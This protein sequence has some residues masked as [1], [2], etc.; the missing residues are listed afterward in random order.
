VR[1]IDP[2]SLI[3]EQPIQEGEWAVLG[4]NLKDE[5]DRSIVRLQV[6]API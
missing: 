3:L 4:L 5:G 2:Q 6:V 1:R